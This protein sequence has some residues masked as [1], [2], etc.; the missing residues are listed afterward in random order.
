MRNNDILRTRL[1]TKRTLKGENTG[2]TE[3]LEVI[4]EREPTYISEGTKKLR[5][6]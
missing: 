2:N 1:V 5:R 6:T 4:E 3:T